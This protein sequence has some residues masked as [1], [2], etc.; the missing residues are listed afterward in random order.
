MSPDGTR[1][2]VMDSTSDEIHWADMS[3]AFDL[4]TLGSWSSESLTSAPGAITALGHSVFW[5]TD[6]LKLFNHDRANER[7]MMSVCSG[8]FD[9]ST[10]ATPSVVLDTSLAMEPVAGYGIG[11]DGLGTKF[12]IIDGGQGD[13]HQYNLSVAYDLTT[14]VHQPAETITT[15]GLGIYG[16]FVRQDAPEIYVCEQ[17]LSRELVKWS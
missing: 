9:P 12:Y 5:S 16:M 2:F 3:S 11:F 13:M 8:A 15:M 6:G 17:A 14:A 1:L 4:S 10:R 7:T